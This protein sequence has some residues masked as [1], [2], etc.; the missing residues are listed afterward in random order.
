MG[1]KYLLPGFFVLLLNTSVA[2]AES[3]SEPRSEKELPKMEESQAS[4]ETLQF[5]EP[6][7]I[8]AKNFEGFSDWSSSST[9]VRKI[10]PPIAL[11]PVADKLPLSTSPVAANEEVQFDRENWAERLVPA[12]AQLKEQTPVTPEN[13][14]EQDSIPGVAQMR[15]TQAAPATGT[16]E[17][18]LDGLNQIEDEQLEGIIFSDE[19][20]EQVTNVSQLRDVEP[21]DWAYQALRSLVERYGCIVGYPDSTF[22]GKRALSR[23]E[24]AAGLNACMEQMER[25]IAASEAVLR[26]DLEK[27]QRLARE[28][29]AELANIAGR[30]D[31]LEGRVAFLEDHQ[32]S[33]T[34]IMNGEVIFAIADAWGG[35]PPGGCRI[36]AEGEGTD[37]T[38][39]RDPAT[40][41]VIANLVRLGLQTSF[42]GKD[43]LRM[44]LTTGNFGFGDS[45]E[46]GSGGGFTNPRSLN[47]YMARF[48]YQAGLDNDIFL[49]I[50][51]YR[52]PAFNDRVVF[53]A[54]AEG[55]T[56][57]SVLSANSP[58]FDIG[59]GAI[60][61]FGQLN[62]ILRIGG[63]MDAGVGF[64]WLIAEPLRLQVAYG[65]RDSGDPEQGFFNSDHSTLGVQLL[66]QPAD[67]LVT[68]ITYVNAY[69]R[70]GALG[71]FTGSVNA[72]TGGLW[73]DARVPAPADQQNDPTFEACCRFFLGD[74]PA[75]INAVGG[76]LQWRLGQNLTFAAWG[77]FIF[78][79][80]IERLPDFSNPFQLGNPDDNGI[81]ASA[82]KKPFAHAATFA[83]SLGFSDPFGREGD[84]FGFI[85]G[86]PPKLVDA[87]PETP[88]TPVPFFEQVVNDENPTTVTDNNPNL[89]TVGEVGA[90]AEATGS[91]AEQAAEGLVAE[92]ELPR[93][94]GQEDEATSLHFEFFYRFKVTDNIWITPGFFFVTNPGHIKDNEIIYVGTIRTTFRF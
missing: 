76:S 50:L 85:F 86:M 57:S 31:N 80:F 30:M 74:Q 33:T 91:T 64:D 17:E 94:V 1:I 82:G 72:E 35:D 70:D 3:S 78:T 62:P 61:R 52:F 53:S 7:I 46:P 25:L 15:E 20:M 11:A 54:A 22:R 12:V 43:R 21:T 26:E 36:V 59:R 42:T 2:K 90:E 27:L 47:T 16:E 24:F 77:G 87:G 49:D 56:L 23:Y 29:E 81:G 73:S 28:F 6:D 88:G 68:G 93:R 8:S 39:R 10:V 79:H 9:L 14:A 41:T 89:D 55:F 38:N 45:D 71:T 58:Y 37:C 44:F 5:I 67:N 4:T 13:V 66:L 75:Q 32:F 48:A 40:N 19:V 18:Y 69:A 51:E 34:T 65:T 83:I 84:L 63:V 92:G 60:S